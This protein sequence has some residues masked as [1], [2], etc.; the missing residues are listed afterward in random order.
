MDWF[1]KFFLALL[2]V[3]VCL[4]LGTPLYQALDLR[5]D[6][7]NADREAAVQAGAGEWHWDADGNK[8][9]RL[10]EGK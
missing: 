6:Q 10:R 1:D 3:G 7:L 8:L 9:F 2:A 5:S 4:I